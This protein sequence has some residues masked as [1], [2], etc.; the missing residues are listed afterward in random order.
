[1]SCDFKDFE[2]H[3]FDNVLPKLRNE[4]ESSF[5]RNSSLEDIVGKTVGNSLGADI[6][7]L[8]HYHKWLTENFNITPK[9]H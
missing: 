9:N 3:Y 6:T 2:N 7:T 1:M 8:S 5:S 4:L